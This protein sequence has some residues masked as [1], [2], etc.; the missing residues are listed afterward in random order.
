MRRFKYGLMV[1][2]LCIIFALKLLKQNITRLWNRDKQ[3]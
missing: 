1:I 2:V 3:D